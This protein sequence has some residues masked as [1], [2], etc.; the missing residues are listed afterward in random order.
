MPMRLALVLAAGLLG[1]GVTRA[2]PQP[3]AE[4]YKGRTI[5]I[6]VGSTPGG[7]YDLYGRTLARHLGKH[8]P[9]EPTVIVQNLAGAG[10]YLAAQRVS[11]IAPQ[12]GLTVGSIGAAQPYQ[13]I[14][15]PK[16]PPLDVKRINWLGS[17]APYHMFMLVRSDVP[18]RSV[19]DLKEHETIQA[20]IAPGQANSL[21]VAVV[22]EVFGA[23]IKGIAG[24]KSMNDAMLALQRGEVNGYPSMPAEAL[25]RTYLKPLQDGEFRLLLQFG[26]HQLPEYKEVP[27]APALA[28]TDEDKLLIELATGFLNTGYVYMMGPDVPPE[29]VAVMRKAMMGALAD[30]TLRAEAKQQTLTIAPIDGEKVTEL[31]ARAYSMPPTVIS[32][33]KQ[34]FA[35]S[36]R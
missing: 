12:D 16:A 25:Q 9:G 33:M 35:V 28:Q 30:P 5:T 14:Y 19:T 27:W 29:R 26:P 32:R 1:V 4:F 8:V 34:V 18:V 21:I 17:I 23:K 3:T 10:S 6:V 24:H 11:S 13:P 7:T 15:D 20:T 22:N 31:L 36:N 2:V